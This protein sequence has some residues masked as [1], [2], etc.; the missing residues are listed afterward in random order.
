MNSN[1]VRGLTFRPDNKLREW[2]EN[3]SKKLNISMSEFVTLVLNDE[4]KKKAEYSI[5]T[6]L[7]RGGREDG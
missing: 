3:N 7:E 6:K 1:I 2:L 4:R 5:R